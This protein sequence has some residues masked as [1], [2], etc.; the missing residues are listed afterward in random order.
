MTARVMHGK[1]VERRATRERRPDALVRSS[2]RRVASGEGRVARCGG[3]VL[4]LEIP[5]AT[6]ANGTSP[7]CSTVNAR[8]MH[9]V[10]HADDDTVL[11]L[12]EV[13]ALE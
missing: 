13:N 11:V 10:G 9:G 2:A 7:S 8:V 1:R 12:V 4:I 3:S 5:G 6:A